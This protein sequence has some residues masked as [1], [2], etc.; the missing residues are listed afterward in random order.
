MATAMIGK[1]T[2][3]FIFDFVL[4]DRHEFQLR[5]IAQTGAN[6]GFHINLV[7]LNITTTAYQLTGLIT[8]YL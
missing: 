8:I 5:C 4:C 3:A 7:A 2:T 1:K 6:C